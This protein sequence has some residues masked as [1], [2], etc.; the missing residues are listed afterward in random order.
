MESHTPNLQWRGYAFH[1]QNP[2]KPGPRCLQSAELLQKIHA[3]FRAPMTLP[4]FSE[5]CLYLDVYTPA[6]QGGG[7]YF[8]VMVF[9]H[10]GALLTGGAAFYDGSALSAYEEV[11]LVVLQYRL[12]ILG[13]LSTGDGQAFGNY[14]FLDQVA[15]LRWIQEN[16]ADF[17]GDPN[18]VTILGESAGAVSVSALDPQSRSRHHV[19]DSTLYGFQMTSPLGKGLFHRAIAESGV[20]LIP[21]VMVHM[22]AHLRDFRDMVATFS[23]C[24]PGSLVDCLRKKSTDEILTVMSQMTL[25]SL[26]VCVDG[27]FLTRPPEET[28]A[29]KQSHNVPFII[30]VNNQECGWMLPKL[31]NASEIL[32]EMDKFTV[33]ETL[34]NFPHLGISS[35]MIPSLLEEYFGDTDNPAE[36]RNRFL[37]LCGDVSL[38][39][40]S[41]RVARYHRDS[42]SSIFFYEF[43]HRPSVLKDTRPDFVK[44]DHGDELMFVFG[45]AFLRAGAFLSMG[46]ATDEE[47]TLSRTVMRYWANFARSGD[48]NGP[49]LVHW[50]LFDH[51]ENYLEISS[52]PRSA[53]NLRAGKAEFWTDVLPEKMQKILKK[54]IE[55]PEL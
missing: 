22:T 3:L 33:Q 9:I 28:L 21:G 11:V 47:K 8:P 48:P 50:P 40:P 39:V 1:T 15:A 13:F 44:S 35:P 42:G 7:R 18:A 29:T 16:I 32:E 2:L 26:P 27:V 4:P 41:F 5:D 6:E 36:L 17:G 43:H 49:G 53:K 10:G 30:G 31:L 12:G 54:N 45:G 52:K 23:G 34:E 25:P 14:G 19:M 24:E 46:D 37:D 20:T 51:K 55:H 38:V